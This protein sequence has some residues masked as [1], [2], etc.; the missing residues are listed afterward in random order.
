MLSLYSGGSSSLHIWNT[1]AAIL[2]SC[3]ICPKKVS[4]KPGWSIMRLSSTSLLSI[5]STCLLRSDVSARLPVL[6]TQGVCW[7]EAVNGGLDCGGVTGV[8]T[9]VKSAL[10]I[11]RSDAWLSTCSNSGI[12]DRTLNSPESIWD[13]RIERSVKRVPRPIRERRA[14]LNKQKDARED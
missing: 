8:A 1:A 13:T 10:Q 3:G 5:G 2:R 7:K 9:S 6:N 4:K 11:S 14:R 12:I